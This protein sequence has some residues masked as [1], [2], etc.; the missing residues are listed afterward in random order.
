MK[1]SV[2]SLFIGC[3]ANIA[4]DPIFIFTLDMGVKGAAIAT[5][6]GNAL[7]LSVYLIVFFT[8]DCSVKFSLKSLKATDKIC[9]KTYVIGIPAA[10]NMAL[11]SLLI[12]ALNGILSKFSDNYVLILGI[13]YKLQTFIYLTANGIVQGIRPLVGYNYGAGENQRVRAIHKVSLI[14]CTIIMAAGTI[15]CLAAPAP[16]MGMFSKN[17]DTISEGAIALRIISCGFIVSSVSVMT[18]GMFEGLG[19]GLPS[20]IISLIRYVLII[21]V[22]LLASRLLGVTGVWHA[23]WI[24]EAIAAAVSTVLYFIYVP[25]VREA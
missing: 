24:T 21:P 14:I 5:V 4:L 12:T 15:L 7:A 19:K 6:I 25:N 17:A 13:Y 2:I 16:L 8:S 11:P 22:A 3:A 1:I 10:L 20:L 18:G 23:F 9:L